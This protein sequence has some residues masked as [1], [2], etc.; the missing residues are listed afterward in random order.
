MKNF[1]EHGT[2]VFIMHLKTLGPK[3]SKELIL[4]KEGDITQNPIV[5]AE[6]G[7]I[8]RP[9]KSRFIPIENSLRQ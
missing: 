5:L 9:E 8:Q 6:Q 4:S 7:M 1:G 2:E 3:Y